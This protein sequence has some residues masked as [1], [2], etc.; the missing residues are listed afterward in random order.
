MVIGIRETE[1]SRQDFRENQE[2]PLG[3]V[4]FPFGNSRA[5]LRTASC[6]PC[7]DSSEIAWSSWGPR[8]AWG[9]EGPQCW[10]WVTTERTKHKAVLVSCKDQ[11]SMF[12]ETEVQEFKCLQPHYQKERCSP[13]RKTAHIELSAHCPRI[14]EEGSPRLTRHR[15][16][17]QIWKRAQ[18]CQLGVVQTS[19]GNQG[20][21]HASGPAHDWLCAKKST[22]LLWP[23]VCL[24]HKVC[25]GTHWASGGRGWA[26]RVAGS[27]I[28]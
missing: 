26:R 8:E 19:A 1:G 18:A 25:S 9:K 5:C 21:P 14:P 4:Q 7:P 3:N 11:H 28:P 22:F 23:P 20:P 12:L 17:N 13:I 6:T 24:I 2:F 10:G 27:L 16:G 15:N